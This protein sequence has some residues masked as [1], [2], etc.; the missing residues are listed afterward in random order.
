MNAIIARSKELATDARLLRCGHPVLMIVFLCEKDGE[1]DPLHTTCARRGEMVDIRNEAI[2]SDLHNSRREQGE[3]IEKE[4]VPS[5]R[6]Y[7]EMVRQGRLSDED[8]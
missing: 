6:L 7:D 3:A 1:T 5:S 4:R 2:G 8:P